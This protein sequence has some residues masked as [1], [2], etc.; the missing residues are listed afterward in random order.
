MKNTGYT[1]PALK[2][3]PYYLRLLRQWRERGSTVA[4]SIAL[5]KA[6][7]VPTP[8]IDAVITLCST[9]NGEDYR[10]IGRSFANLGLAGKSLD[11]IKDIVI[12]GF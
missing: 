4:S 11:E 12:N 8:H 1:I 3:L 6:A 9:F 2:R 7:G 5:A 10:T